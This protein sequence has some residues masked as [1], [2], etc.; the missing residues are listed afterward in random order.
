MLQAIYIVP[1][2]GKLGRSSVLYGYCLWVHIVVC[3]AGLKSGMS[4]K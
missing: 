1:L 3:L 4:Y 2:Q